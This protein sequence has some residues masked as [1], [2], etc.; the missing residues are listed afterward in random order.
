VLQ[1]RH[2]KLLNKLTGCPYNEIKPVKFGYGVTWSVAT[3]YSLASQEVPDN[4]ALCVLRVQSYMANVDSTASD[5]QFYRAMPA[6]VAWWIQA[7]GTGFTNTLQTWTN[8][9]APAFLA[10]DSDELLLFP[11][12]ANANLLFTAA[13]T[14]P[15]GSWQMRTTVYGYLV[16]PRVTDALSGPQNWINVQQ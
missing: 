13:G 2:L 3:T 8:P 12:G 15:A 6:G 7:I 14:A 4:M 11:G 16:P 1:L 10:C 9:N 5:F